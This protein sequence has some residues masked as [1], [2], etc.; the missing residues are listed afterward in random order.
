MNHTTT[1][2]EVLSLAAIFAGMTDRR[3]SKGIRYEFQTLLILLSLSK[4]C[5]QDTPS[6]IAEW[7]LNRS[8]LLRA[9]LGLKWKRMPSLSTWQR[10]VGQN[11]EAAVLDEK[12]GEYFQSLSAEERQL[13]NLD[14]K[15]V[16]GT[17][18]KLGR[19]HLK[20]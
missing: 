17:I 5:S 19:T 14:G 18:D 16:C 9:K 15:V 20:L 10:L 4:L 3:K 1:A 11:I 7:V 6:E 12:V 8:A 2:N 13:Y